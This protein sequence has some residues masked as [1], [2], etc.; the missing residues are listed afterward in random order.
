MPWHLGQPGN[1]RVLRGGS[2]NNNNQNARA[3]YRNR[4]NPSNRN[5]NNGFR[6]VRRPT[7]QLELVDIVPHFPG[8]VDT[9]ITT[10]SVW[11][12]ITTRFQYMPVGD[13]FMVHLWSD[14]ASGFYLRWRGFVPPDRSASARCSRWRQ[15]NIKTGPVPGCAPAPA[16]PAV[17]GHPFKPGDWLVPLNLN[18]IEA[19]VWLIQPPSSRPTS[20][21]IWLMC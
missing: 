17:Q 6:L 19:S 20:L 14:A 7:S 3:A 21:T 5:N 9:R 12:P 15:V 11:P 8:G 16:A 13:S 10:A 1:R 2:W 18:Y 4:N